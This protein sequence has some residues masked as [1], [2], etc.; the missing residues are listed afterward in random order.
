MKVPL[1]ASQARAY[2]IELLSNKD[3]GWSL[4]I[5]GGEETG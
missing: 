4:R 2:K 1:S 3:F 5:C